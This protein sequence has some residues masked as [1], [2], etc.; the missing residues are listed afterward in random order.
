VL[1]D[2][3][4]NSVSFKNVLILLT[5]N[6][7]AETIAAASRQHAG[8]D[9]AQLIRPELLARLPAALLGRMVAIPYLPLGEAEIERVARLKLAKVQ[10]RFLDAYDAELT[11]DED[12]A[13]AIALRCTEVETGARNIDHILTNTVLPGLSEEVLA[14]MAEEQSFTACHLGLSPAGMV[15]YRF[16]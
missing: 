9:L 2:A 14:R 1:E 4:G 6:L 3:D 10:E 7:G 12:L 16:T 13:R 15:T 8:E 11:Y 5:S